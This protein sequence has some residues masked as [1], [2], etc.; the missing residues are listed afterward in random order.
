[1]ARRF[2]FVLI[3]L[4]L[5]SYVSRREGGVLVE[6]LAL[7]AALVLYP[8]AGV[9]ILAVLAAPFVYGLALFV[10]W[11]WMRDG[12]LPAW[13]ARPVGWLGARRPWCYRLRL[14]RAGR[15]ATPSDTPEAPGTSADGEAIR[16][17]A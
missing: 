13:V 17:G 2:A 5:I 7:P 4:A 11:R 10:L 12:R 14:E 9:V 15:P 16:N 3:G 1:M 8:F 6:L